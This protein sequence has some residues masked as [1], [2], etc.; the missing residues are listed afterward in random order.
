MRA[1]QAVKSGSS[2]P[3]KSQLAASGHHRSRMR[4]WESAGAGAPVTGARLYC[5]RAV[6]SVP[7]AWRTRNER[8]ELRRPEQRVSQ[9]QERALPKLQPPRS[10]ALLEKLI[11]LILYG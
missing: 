9:L 7:A 10:E 3:I 5:P 4:R 6:S 11:D 2:T 8:R 1:T